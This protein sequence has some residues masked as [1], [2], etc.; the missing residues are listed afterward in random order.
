MTMET[1]DLWKTLSQQLFA[2]IDDSFVECFRAPGGA[3]NRLAAWD[4]FDPTMRYFKLL[5]FNA[6]KGQPDRFFDLYRML[7]DTNLGRPIVIRLRGCEV[8]IDHLFAVEEFMFLEKAIDLATVK[9]VVEIGAGFGRTC[10]AL[11][12]LAPSIRNYTIVDLP[13]VL[14]L[15]RHVLKRLL[16][17][18]FSKVSFVDANNAEAWQGISADLAINI[19]SFQE[20]PPATIDAYRKGI[21]RNA[22]HVYIKNPVGKY[23]PESIGIPVHDSARFHDVFS[24]GYCRDVIDI[25]DDRALEKARTRYVDAYRPVEGWRTLADEPLGAVPYLHHVVYGAG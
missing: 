15:S 12:R 13:N 16:P 2:N 17:D 3:N 9:S 22:R 18:V 10:H 1:S 24:L 7:G 4:P 25:F 23:A 11:T 8:N 19:D 14:D 21:L 6:A 20:M 5:L